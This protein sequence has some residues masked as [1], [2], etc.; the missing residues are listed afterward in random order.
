MAQVLS[1][2]I[3]PPAQNQY[4]QE[5]ILGELIFPRIHAGPVFALA[6]IQKILLRSHFLHISQ[7][8]EGNYFGAYTCRACIR[9]RANTG[10]YSWGIIYVLVSC[11]GVSFFCFSV[12]LCLAFWASLGLNGLLGQALPKGPFSTKTCHGTRIRIFLPTP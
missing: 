2:L 6:R 1:P 9:T 4:M 7:I 8:L 3:D 12:R 5:K 11:Q 10:K